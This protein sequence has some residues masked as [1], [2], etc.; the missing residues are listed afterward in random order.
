MN[1]ELF[2]V[3]VRQGKGGDSRVSSVQVLFLFFKEL[4]CTKFCC[5]KSG[6]YGIT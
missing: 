3:N 1:S 2:F 4:S 5:S 6:F